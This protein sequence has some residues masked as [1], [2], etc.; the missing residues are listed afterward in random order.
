[1]LMNPY[2]GAKQYDPKDMVYLKNPEQSA[3]F[4]KYI[5]LYDVILSADRFTYVFKKVDADPL[6]VRWRNFDLK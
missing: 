6:L 4:A 2:C 5:Y 3:R 1:M